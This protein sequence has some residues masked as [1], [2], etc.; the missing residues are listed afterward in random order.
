MLVGIG[1]FAGA[2]GLT[3]VGVRIP[4][5]ASPIEPRR[6]AGASYTLLMGK[7]DEAKRGNR[8]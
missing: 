3:R 1:A 7:T 6:N 5:I 4:R 8:E 2:L